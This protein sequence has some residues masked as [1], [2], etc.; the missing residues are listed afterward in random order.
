M[1]KLTIGAV[2]GAISL[3]CAAVAL[4]VTNTITY[5]ASVNAKAPHKVPVNAGLHSVF[6]S[7][8]PGGNTQP[9]TAFKTEVFFAK[10]FR[11]NAKH[12]PAC[13]AAQ[14][15]NKAFPS[16][17]EKA[18]VGGGMAIVTAAAPGSA[19]NPATRETLTVDVVNG[20]TGSTAAAR[21]RNRGKRVLLVLNGTT[22]LPVKNRVIAGTLT[23]VKGTAAKKFGYELVFRVPADLQKVPGTSL[24]VAVR[25]LTIAVT[26]AKKA[27]VKVGGRKRSVS[28][29]QLAACPKSRKLPTRARAHFNNDDGTP[30]TATAVSNG[31]AACK[32]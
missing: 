20:T 12:F 5:T 28:Y 7:N 30:G 16:V 18:R 9:D 21:K 4:A 22:P 25:N 11:N 13:T 24:Q 6:T 8:G 10:Q 17:C 19:D 32:R 29:L 23:K 3:V 2:V 1:R 14:I 15:D 27:K 26:T 31:S